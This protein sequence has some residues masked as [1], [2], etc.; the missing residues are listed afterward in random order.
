[1]RALAILFLFLIMNSCFSQDPYFDPWDTVSARNVHGKVLNLNYRMLSGHARYDQRYRVLGN[2]NDDLHNIEINY[3]LQ[4]FISGKNYNDSSIMSSYR[5]I[6]I[7]DGPILLDMIGDREILYAAWRNKLTQSSSESEIKKRMIEGT[8]ALIATGYT[9]LGEDFLPF[10]TGLMEEQHI[11]N[12]DNTRTKAFGAGSRGIVTSIQ[13]LN[14]LYSQDSEQNFGVCRDVHE[15]GREL[16]KTMAETWYGHFYPELK[17]DFDDYIFLQSWTTNKSHHVTTSLIDPLDT[18]RV[19]EIDW[20]RVIE[21]RD[22][23]GYNNGRLY[24]NNYR[25]WKFDPGKQITV[26]VDFRRTHFGKI[27]D[28]NILT[29]QEYL[30]FNGIYDEET[31]SDLRYSRD[32]GKFGWTSFS[33]GTYNPGQHYFLAGWVYETKKKRITSFLDHSS[34]LAV[35]GVIHEDTRKKQI[36]FSHVDWQFAGSIMGIPRIISKFSSKEFRIAPNLTA[37]AYLNQQFDIFLIGNTF[38]MSDSIDNND[39]SGSGDGNISFSNGITL[40]YNPGKR[41]YSSSALQARS[42]L[43]PNDIR[44]FTPN[45]VTLVPALRFITPAIDAMTMGTF[46]VNNKSRIAYDLMLEFTSLDAIIFSGS[47]SGRI[48]ISDAVHFDVSAGT[49][50][51]VKGIEYF[52]YPASRAW[53]DIRITRQKNSFSASVLKYAGS[54]VSVNFSFRK[55][56]R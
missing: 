48:N 44:L 29:R 31:Y 23:A 17:T 47:G 50:R 18:K 41:F 42:C 8:E 6:N 9:D 37:R 49:I 15:M 3:L 53:V 4:N 27:L 39:L 55:T 16:L 35:Q 24:G 1:M 21:K 11:V 25:I 45:L 28:E 12:Y 2:Y 43:L 40:L 56:L 51:Q 26:P 14:A 19:Y 36:M 38:Y 20:G 7:S 52:W 13:I 34:L 30:Q 5:F 10:I 33:V 54:N 22:N 46:I 32:V